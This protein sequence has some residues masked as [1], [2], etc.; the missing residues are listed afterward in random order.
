MT[1]NTAI[2][3]IVKKWIVC[4]REILKIRS[5]LKFFDPSSSVSPPMVE[6]I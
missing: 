5:I 3:V 4:G 1:F 2:D 6:K